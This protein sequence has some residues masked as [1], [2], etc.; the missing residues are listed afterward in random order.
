M[1][2][3]TEKLKSV[4]T[5]YVDEDQLDNGRAGSNMD[6]YS[7]IKLSKTS[8]NC[9]KRRQ[10]I[11]LVPSITNHRPSEV[12]FHLRHRRLLGPSLAN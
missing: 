8:K 12:H 9:W 4:E 2:N 6:N 3:E 7:N 1:I 5:E 11:A 10:A